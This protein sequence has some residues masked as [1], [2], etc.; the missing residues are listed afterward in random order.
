M[1]F[2]PAGQLQAIIGLRKLQESRQDRAEEQQRFR[3]AKSAE[4]LNRLLGA[5]DQDEQFN[6]EVA[7]QN[8][9]ELLPQHQAALREHKKGRLRQ[10]KRQ[11]AET[12]IPALA[13][14]A[15]TQAA[16]GER[17]GQAQ[18][19]VQQ[20]TDIQ[21]PDERARLLN[22]L[23][24]GIELN[25]AASQL[26]LPEQVAETNRSKQNIRLAEAAQLREDLSTRAVSMTADH[27][28]DNNFTE[29]IVNKDFLSDLT[30][31]LSKSGA[32]RTEVAHAVSKAEA[33][34]MDEAR[35]RLRELQSSSAGRQEAES[36]FLAEKE[37]LQ[38]RF[39]GANI[40][41][42]EIRLMV[43]GRR[44]EDPLNDRWYAAGEELLFLPSNNPAEANRIRETRRNQGILLDM[45]DEAEAS[46]RE[47]ERAHANGEAIAGPF[48]TS[49]FLD[50]FSQAGVDIGPAAAAYKNF[51]F[52]FVSTLLRARQ[53]SRPSDFDLRM[54]LALMPMPSEVGLSSAVGKFD[55][56]RKSLRISL[57]AF[58]DPIA[59][60][61]IR[62]AKRRG[63][64]SGSAADQRVNNRVVN[65]LN[66]ISEKDE[67]GMWQPRKDITPEDM[68]RVAGEVFQAT[69]D[70][71]RQRAN[72]VSGVVDE[73]VV[74][75]F[76]DTAVG[77][78]GGPLSRG[79]QDLADE[80]GIL[81]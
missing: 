54:Y 8:A 11:D 12:N 2:D 15:T 50:F 48:I 62:E 55:A 72:P 77:V 57:R 47:L 66:S 43:A 6:V 20:I 27:I 17:G 31:T 60:R 69:S 41:D 37:S 24:Q 30:E 16:S 39:P 10:K 70:W 81:E 29:G 18:A 65:A 34:G 42:S 58:G 4:S 3:D 51:G 13:Q 33:F 36:I 75:G 74:E 45:F 28:L 44:A 22:Q 68:N 73:W 76:Q 80:M 61:Q 63:A 79:A 46:F 25:Q 64:S 5:V 14:L 52:E 26:R 49:N 40:P 9:P 59:E 38:R 53:G 56:M 78:G 7:I 1:A 71:H 23:G 32:P 21:N 67:N 19:G 35:R